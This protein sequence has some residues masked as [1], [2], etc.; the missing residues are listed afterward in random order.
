MELR[1]PWSAIARDP[2]AEARRRSAGKDTPQGCMARS[3]PSEQASASMGS[4]LALLCGNDRVQ[5]TQASR[6]RRHRFLGALSRSY[7]AG[8]CTPPN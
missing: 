3:L 5:V 1:R 4:D 6:F 2:T 7:R 8:V